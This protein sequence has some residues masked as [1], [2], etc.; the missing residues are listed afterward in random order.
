[1]HLKTLRAQY[2]LYMRQQ[3]RDVGAT[4]HQEHGLTWLDLAHARLSMV[5]FADVMRIIDWNAAIEALVA[6]ANTHN[7]FVEWKTFDWDITP[8]LTDAL[9][10]HD[11]ESDDP[12]ACMV[13]TISN[14]QEMLRQSPKADVRIATR[15]T[16]KDADVVNA[17]VRS[18]MRTTVSEHVLPMWDDDP[19]S[20]SVHIAYVDGDPASYGRVEFPPE[21]PFAGIWAGA[22]LPKYRQRG[23]YTALVASR[24]QEARQRG[25]AYLT[26]DADPNTSMPILQKLGFQTIGTTT[27]YTYI[28]PE[29]Y[30][31]SD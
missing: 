27:P 2:D 7:H 19:A 5:L 23:L 28:P 20:M 13:L 14:A 18:Q 17:V 15:E 4:Y 26:V 1:M 22:T 16:L 24:M 25:Y 21:N 31:E 11:F 30:D 29:N 12:E 8:K 3:F 9:L 6:Y 10:A